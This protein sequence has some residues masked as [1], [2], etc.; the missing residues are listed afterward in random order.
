MQTTSPNKQQQMGGGL[1]KPGGIT[2]NTFVNK[3]FGEDEDEDDDFDTRLFRHSTTIV[4]KRHQNQMNKKPKIIQEENPNDE[5]EERI[6]QAKEEKQQQQQQQQQ[7][8]RMP[9][10]EK[11]I[12]QKSQTSLQSNNLFDI[13]M[14]LSPLLLKVNTL[15]F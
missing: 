10:Q 11:K 9:I 7:Q 14:Y 12:V 5:L 13:F 6:Q 15:K 2:L 8:M 4:S 3:G 1:N